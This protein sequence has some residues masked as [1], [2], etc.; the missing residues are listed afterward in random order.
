VNWVLNVFRISRLIG[1]NLR[2]LGALML[3]GGVYREA[4]W[5]AKFMP[6]HVVHFLNTRKKMCFVWPLNVY[7]YIDPH[8][9]M[10][11]CTISKAIGA[12]CPWKICVESVAH[13]VNIGNTMYIV[14]QEEC[15]IS[16]LIHTTWWNTVYSVWEQGAGGRG[17]FRANGEEVTGGRKELH[18]GERH[19]L[20]CII[21][22]IS[23]RRMK[24]DG[25]VTRKEFGSNCY[26]RSCVTE[27]SA[28][29]F[30]N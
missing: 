4:D 29:W 18:S 25:R 16:I 6:K 13:S 27:L 14:W 10:Q 15:T 3:G 30:L 7:I 12:V 2:W 1:N 19:L 22:V 28:G 26:C 20:Y 21:R 24:W 11:R 23:S 17:I 9:M 8:D 5:Y